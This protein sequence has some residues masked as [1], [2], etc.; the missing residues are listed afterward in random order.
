[1]ASFKDNAE[2]ELLTALPES[3]EE[4]RAFLSAAAKQGGY[5]HMVGRR[6]NLVFGL[7]SYEECLAVVRLLR[8]LYPSEFEISASRIKTGSKKGNTEFSVAVPTGY[9]AQAVEDL[10]LAEGGVPGFVKRSRTA[11]ESYLK[12]LFLVCGS[13]YVPSTEGD[14]EKREGYHFEFALDGGEYAAEVKKKCVRDG[15]LRN[16]YAS[17]RK[18]AE[19]KMVIA[20]AYS[21]LLRYMG[22]VP[23]LKHAVDPNE[24][25]NFPR[26]TF[27]ETVDYIVQL[28]DEAAPYLNW[29]NDGIENGRMTKAG[30][31]G[32]KLRILLWAASPTFNSASPWH[33]EAD[34][35][36]CYGNY[37]KERW[38]RAMDAGE[39]FFEELE[40]N[41]GYQLTQAASPTHSGYRAAFRSAYYDRGGTEVLISTRRGYNSDILDNFLTEAKYSG[42]TLN[43]VNMFSWDDGTDFPENFD[44]ENPSRQPF[45]DAD[46]NPTREPRLYETCAVP[47]DTWRDGS[48]APVYTNHPNYTVGTGFFQMKFIL[49]QD[50]DREGKPVQWPYLRLPE[51]ML[52][53]A[54]AINE[55]NGGPD[56]T[57]YEQI[58]AVRNRVG[59]PDLQAGLGQTEFRE[60]LLRERALEFGYEEV[61]WF[62]LVRWGRSED[63][64]KK[65]YGLQV[66]G[67]GGTTTNPASYTFRRTEL[68]TRNWATSWDTKWYLAAF[69]Q[70][71]VDKDYGLVQNPGW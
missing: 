44:W 51:V 7:S 45:Y 11:A 6:R 18:V 41:G 29:K 50:S 28:L 57:A 58:N 26:A 5:L 71:E 21:E 49:N 70:T 27:A 61:R 36:T 19:A 37:D 42:P 60:A 8:V 69:P 40:A 43:Y 32:L 48:V 24:D 14:A 13:V 15:R 3:G 10:C 52:S 9:A 55:Y 2:K 63:F 12:G 23:L 62:D 47:G 25:M 59:L 65:L 22:G 30:A 20:I 31:M 16:R 39:A 1:M 4:V 54:E 33:P 66:T 67:V 56:A 53:Y 17:Q 35:Y 34:E 68:A 64:T 38:K 46:G